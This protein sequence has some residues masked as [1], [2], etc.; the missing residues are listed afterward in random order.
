MYVRTAAHS[1]M[2]TCVYNYTHRTPPSASANDQ[3]LI[4]NG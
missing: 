3:L 2:S 4:D 1:Q